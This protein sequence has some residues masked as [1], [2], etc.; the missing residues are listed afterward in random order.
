[1]AKKDL[2]AGITI[3]NI[4][5]I[6]QLVE[7]EKSV[8]ILRH[9]ICVNAQILNDIIKKNHILISSFINGFTKAHN[10][11]VQVVMWLEDEMNS[12]YQHLLNGKED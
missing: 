9:I 2:T 1:M 3:K 10:E 6:P 5:T 4:I 12:M 8:K 7:I 11:Q